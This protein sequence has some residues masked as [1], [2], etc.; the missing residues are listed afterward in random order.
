MK[1]NHRFFGGENMCYKDEVQK[2]NGK[3]FSRILDADNVPAFIRKYFI[4]LTSE[5]SKINYWVAIKDLLTWAIDNDLIHKSSI[6]DISPEDMLEIEA[7]DITMYLQE[8]EKHSMSPTTLRTRKNI[9]GSFWEYLV[10]TNKVPVSENV[11]RRVTYKGSESKNVVAKTPST[12]ELD[13]MEERMN[14]KKDD[15]VRERNKIIL[16]VLRGTGIRESELAG[17]DLDDI[18][19]KGSRE[20]SRPHIKVFG[21]GK[22]RASEMRIVLITDDVIDAFLSWFKIRVKVKNIKDKNA[23]FLNKN[24][25]RLNEENIKSIFKTYGNGITPHMVR[26]WYGSVMIKKYGAPFVQQQMG[27]KDI[28]LTVGTY[29]DGTFDVNLASV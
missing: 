8:K 3:K 24:G 23:A 11:V 17:L 12:E 29:V 16:R 6:A 27:H 1:R 28:N 21:K 4:S 25:K 10:H 7:E 2:K 9:I 5:A 18:F 13:A 19:L 14:K 20:E 15:F 26:H 22:Y